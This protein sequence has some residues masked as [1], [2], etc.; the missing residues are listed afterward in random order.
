MTVVQPVTQL[1]VVGREPTPYGSTARAAHADAGCDLSDRT[2]AR[3]IA[4]AREAAYRAYDVAR[5]LVYD[6]CPHGIDES[7]LTP[8]QRTALADLQRAEARLDLLCLTRWAACI[9][10]AS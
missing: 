3:K 6:P 4:T 8:A 2:L 9:D 10:A 5:R 1:A 7:A